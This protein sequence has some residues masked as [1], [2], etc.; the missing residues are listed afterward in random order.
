MIR[1]VF[2]GYMWKIAEA[3]QRSPDH[4]LIAVGIEPQRMRSPEAQRFFDAS[5]QRSF[6]ASKIRQHA[7]FDALLDGGVDLLIVGAFGQMLSAE[8]L[9]RV[10]LGT[11]NFHPSRL[12]H[13]RGGSPLEEQLLRG[14][15]LGGVSAHWMVEEVD[16]GALIAT[17]EMP[18]TSV[19]D[20]PAL[21]ERSHSAA[22]ELMASLLRSHP[23]TWPRIEP[24]V[25][26][27]VCK[28]RTQAD[29]RIHW[30]ESAAT[31]DRLVRALGWRGWPQCHRQDGTVLVIESS[32]VVSVRPPNSKPGQVMESGPEPLIATGDGLLRL[33]RFRSERELEI[34][35]VLSSDAT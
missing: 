12:P 1:C 22:G 35:E 7:E 26:T 17:R 33:T 6:D 10:H 5:R 2:L 31:I 11:I 19:D 23:S 13:Y 4:D 20:Y 29:A 16:A 15:T 18:I 3:V 14:E 21:Y 9:S 8:I 30:S 27:P 24:D 28:P 34:G 25:G 32:S